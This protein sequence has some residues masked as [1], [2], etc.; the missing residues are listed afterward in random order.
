MSKAL[1]KGGSALCYV[2]GYE[3]PARSRVAPPKPCWGA[4]MKL[5][6]LC[7]LAP[8][9]TNSSFAAE[10]VDPSPFI[11]ACSTG[12]SGPLASTSTIVFPKVGQESEV[13]IGQSVISTSHG[14][15]M[16]GA[17][18]LSNDISISASYIKEF[19]V[20]L[21][22]GNYNPIFGKNGWEHII[23]DSIFRYGSGQ[24]RHGL[25]K[26]D[27][28]IFYDKDTEN[29]KARVY[30]GLATKTIELPTSGIFYDAYPY[31]EKG[32]DVNCY[33]LGFQKEL[34]LL[35]TESS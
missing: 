14:N 2:Q 28:V 13:E 19:T 3:R 16:V 31:H 8:I 34:Y 33:I 35:S 17:V 26:P 18:S 23:S 30:L 10:A 24:P 20:Q 4:K 15:I 25:S 9:I 29:F 6:M 1:P 11:P 5:R 22:A 7:A 32:F 21:P 12:S 27:T